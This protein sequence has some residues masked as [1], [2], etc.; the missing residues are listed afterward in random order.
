VSID[1]RYPPN[2]TAILSALRFGFMILTLKSAAQLLQ[3]SED[4]VSRWIQSEKLPIRTVQDR[5]QFDRFELLEWAWRNKKP[6][7][8]SIVADGDAWT[9][10]LAAALEVG[11]I[12]YHLPGHDKASVYRAMIDALP[13]PPEVDRDH[14]MQVLLARESLCPTSMGDGLAI[15]HPRNP[16]VLHIDQ[17]FFAIAFPEK[18]IEDFG[19]I[20]SKPIKTLLLLIS[21]TVRVHLRILAALTAALHSPE[22]LRALNDRVTPEELIAV[23]DQADRSSTAARNSAEVGGSGRNGS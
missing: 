20:D 16:V 3:V 17:P 6:I 12:H 2:R 21:P 22:V 4:Q 18:P 1:T 19:A 13:L 5:I 15:P 10:L 11:G 23:L 14:L 7:C 9:P 8:P